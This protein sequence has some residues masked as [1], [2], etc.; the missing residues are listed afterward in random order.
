MSALTT[1]HELNLHPTS[2]TIKVTH[3]GRPSSWQQ[4]GLKFWN[5]RLWNPNMFR[6]DMEFEFKVDKQV[7]TITDAIV[8]EEFV[9]VKNYSKVYQITIIPV[10][11][12]DDVPNSNQTEQTVR[13]SI[14]IQA[15]ASLGSST[16]K[17]RLMDGTQKVVAESEEF[18]VSAPK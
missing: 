3:T 2:S 16:I 17:F 10:F 9:E 6:I 7:V 14:N 11:V 1:V 13:E 5:W 18:N 8:F 4:H 12:N 15:G